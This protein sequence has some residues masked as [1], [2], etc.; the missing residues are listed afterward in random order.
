VLESGRIAFLG[1]PDEFE[2]SSLPAVTK[3]THPSGSIRITDSYIAD[4][5]GPARKPGKNRE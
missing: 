3:L 2:N 1:D 4:P 5:W